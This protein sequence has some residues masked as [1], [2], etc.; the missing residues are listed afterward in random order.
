MPEIDLRDGKR[1]GR[2]AHPLATSV[3]LWSHHH[4]SS[5]ELLLVRAKLT[6]DIDGS[7]LFT[8]GQ[9]RTAAIGHSVIH[10]LT[11]SGAGEGRLEVASAAP[12]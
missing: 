12:G 3:R 7:R 6:G 8:F 2:L 9:K 10:P 1:D 4:Q 5:T 11:Y